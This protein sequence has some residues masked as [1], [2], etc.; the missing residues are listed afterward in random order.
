M[1]WL[2]G[3]L[4]PFSW[5]HSRAALYRTCPRRY[6]Y[7]YYAPYGRNSP[8]EQG[9]RTLC[10]LLGKLSVVP[11]M[12]GRVVHAL[13]D[14]SLRAA[15]AG[16]PW[17]AG[18]LEASARVSLTRLI[19][20]SQ[21]AMR[22][23]A[24]SRP[25]RTAGTI[26]DEHY[27][28]LPFGPEA[29]GAALDRAVTYARRL[30]QHPLYALALACPERVLSLEAVGRMEV[31]GFPVYAVPDLVLRLDDGRIAVVDWKTGA[32]VAERLAQHAAQ[33]AVYALYVA[34]RWQVE[35]GRLTGLVADLNEGQSIE[36]PFGE[37][38]MRRVEEEIAASVVCLR[39]ALDD[40]DANVA[41]ARRFPPL[42][43]GSMPLGDLPGA[44]VPCPFRV[45]CYGE[46]VV[47]WVPG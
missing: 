8:A 37:G 23:P 12:V 3:R 45:L 34:G 35:E 16:N 5:S 4:Q 38:A 27:Y 25:L 41:S 15:M 18:S 43:A 24:S 9:D 30:H 10:H 44:C 17:P 31:A 1:T 46:R 47:G 13:A 33:L 22:A 11:M 40:P 14:G 6:Y 32:A 21:R 36:V 7:R 26:L 19:R 39:A 29:E 20:G 28:R 42:A 2:E